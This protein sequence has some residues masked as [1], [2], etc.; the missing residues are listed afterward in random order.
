MLLYVWLSWV[1]LVKQTDLKKVWKV[2][3]KING[4]L[5]PTLIS[6]FIASKEANKQ[7]RNLDEN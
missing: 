4:K 7:R 3:V 5:Q 2:V 1:W 6:K